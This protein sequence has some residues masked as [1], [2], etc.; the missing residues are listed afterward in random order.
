[1]KKIFK[2]LFIFICFFVS[3]RVFATELNTTSL[4]ISSQS[5]TC[6]EILGPNLVKI[7]KLF[8]TGLRIAAAIIAIIKGM[9]GFIPAIAADSAP[10]K[11][12]ADVHPARYARQAARERADLQHGMHHL[13]RSRHHHPRHDL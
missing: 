13:R 3:Y 1:M 7:V 2:L 10:D 5:M 8:V 6:A 12:R 11:Q 9:L 4:D